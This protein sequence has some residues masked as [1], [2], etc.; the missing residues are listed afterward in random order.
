MKLAI[1]ALFMLNQAVADPPASTQP[2]TRGVASMSEDEFVACARAGTA[3][4][5]D[6]R[7]AVLEG[8]RRIGRDFPGMGEH[9]IRVGLVFDGRFD[10][11]RPEVLN[12]IVIDGKPQ[13]LGVAYA[14]PLLRGEKAPDSPAGPGAWH[15]HSRTI[16]DET[17]LPHHHTSGSAGAEAR[18]AMLHAWIWSPNPDGMFAADNWAIPFF[19]RKLDPVAAALPLVAKALALTSGGRDYFEKTIH[20]GAALTAVEKSGVTKAMDEARRQSNRSFM[21][22]TVGCSANARAQPSPASGRGSGTSSTQ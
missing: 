3:K 7:T 11:S 12:Y 20:A 8:Y 18:L 22:F 6:Q 9:W 4:Y 2:C 17:V 16:E 1:A 15:D 19:R 13:L 21:D 5:R 10:P 14:V